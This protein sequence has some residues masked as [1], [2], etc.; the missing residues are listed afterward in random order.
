M[1]KVKIEAFLS[2]PTCSGG[3]ALSRL[4]KEIERDY[5]NKVEIFT[6]K[7][8]NELFQE[9]RLTAAPAIVVEELVRI[10]GTC[11]SKETL[12]AALYEAGME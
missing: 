8:N 12:I 7:G 11:P 2:V 10:M 1:S 9:Y 5:N 4:L 6:Y 3:I